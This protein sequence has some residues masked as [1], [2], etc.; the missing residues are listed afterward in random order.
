METSNEEFARKKHKR[1]SAFE[2][3]EKKRR[4]EE[5]AIKRSHVEGLAFDCANHPKYDY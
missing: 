2:L 5:S 4:K 1:L 3:R